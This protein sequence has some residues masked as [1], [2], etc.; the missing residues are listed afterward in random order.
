MTPYEEEPLEPTTE[1]LPP[2]LVSEPRTAARPRRV[3]PTP[4]QQQAEASL[5]AEFKRRQ[6]ALLLRC[7]LPVLGLVSVRYGIQP[8]TLSAWYAQ[9]EALILPVASALITFVWG[10]LAVKRNVQMLGVSMWME[11]LQHDE[12]GERP[13]SV[14]DVQAMHREM[15][16][17]R[18]ARLPP[19]RF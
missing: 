2:L 1:P 12:T 11:P 19:P 13:I 16:A 9:H 7:L 6:L 15:Q 17:R 14:A 4:P 18:A 10:R 5:Q 8:A 3:G